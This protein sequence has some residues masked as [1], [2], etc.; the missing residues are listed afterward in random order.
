M[1][2]GDQRRSWQREDCPEWCVVAHAEDDHSSDRRHMSRQTPVPV[3]ALAERSDPQAP[4][5]DQWSLE[6]FVLCLQRKDGSEQTAVYVGDGRE[7][8]IEIDVGSARRV[9]RSLGR[10]VAGLPT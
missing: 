5:R 3:L 2:A 4:G 6:E 9:A 7:Q 8:R 1:A 10:I